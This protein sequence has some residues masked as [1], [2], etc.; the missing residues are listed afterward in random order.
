[1]KNLAN[2]LQATAHPVPVDDVR[3]LP[4]HDPAGTGLAASA[5]PPV[6]GRRGGRGITSVNARDTKAL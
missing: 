6:L 3:S 5:F 1:M 2:A 4:A